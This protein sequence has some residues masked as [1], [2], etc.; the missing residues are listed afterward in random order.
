MNIYLKKKEENKTNT[1]ITEVIKY[2]RYLVYF[3]TYQ[4][5]TKYYFVTHPRGK[6]ETFEKSAI[7]K[8]YWLSV[9]SSRVVISKCWGQFWREKLKM[10]KEYKTYEPSF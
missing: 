1:V 5:S 7:C 2:L 8:R 6:E 3:C 4:N 10:K 9:F